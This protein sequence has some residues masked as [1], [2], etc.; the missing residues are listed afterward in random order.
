MKDKKLKIHLQYSSRGKLSQDLLNEILGIAR[1]HGELS[2]RQ[3][4]MRA[5]SIDL[6][7]ILEIVGVFAGMKILD[8]LFEG[9]VGK[10][11]F[12]EIGNK[13]RKGAFELTDRMRDFLVDL[14]ENVVSKNVDR[15]GAFVI[16]EYINDFSLYIVLNNKRMTLNLMEKIPEAIALS[17]IVTASIEVEDDNPRIIQLYPNFETETWDYILMP[18]T[19]AFGK[20]VDRY[21]DLVERSLKYL[22][23]SY[24]FIEKFNPDDK[25]DFKF[26]IN[27]NRNHDMSKFDE[28]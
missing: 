5:R 11:I 14:F 1:K 28:L 27:P 10:D 17:I 2:E 26:L 3:W 15:Y 16:V 18:T 8:G 7:T 9:L 13:F 12:K 22:S 20:Y 24:E 21:F 23:S 4:G 6:V 25:D 19:Q